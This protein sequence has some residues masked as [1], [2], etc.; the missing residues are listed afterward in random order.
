MEVCC[1]FDPPHPHLSLLAP[2][3][4]PTRK[5]SFRRRMLGL[6]AEK[7]RERGRE[8]GSKTEC[9]GERKEER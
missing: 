2:I 8:K 6:K 9:E 1:I 7:E 5:G 4:Y 3:A